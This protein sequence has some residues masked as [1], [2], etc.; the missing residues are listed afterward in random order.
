MRE[1]RGRASNQPCGRQ[2]GLYS[3]RARAVRA[4]FCKGLLL[5]LKAQDEQYRYGIPYWCGMNTCHVPCLPLCRCAAQGG[6]NYLFTGPAPGQAQHQ[7]Y[8]HH[9]QQPY[10]QQA[11]PQ[12]PGL[13][14]P[15]HQYLH[16]Q[17]DPASYPFYYP[18]GDVG[19]AG[20][21]GGGERSPPSTRR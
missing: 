15:A 7:T 11:D 8:M 13:P 5:E 19:G 3:N 20:G 10:Q 4:S 16:Q 2:I 12:Q 21:F 6:Y 17:L 9:Q 18:P 14:L 1:S